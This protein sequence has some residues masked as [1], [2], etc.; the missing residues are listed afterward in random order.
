MGIFSNVFLLYVLL[1]QLYCS[2]PCSVLTYFSLA[3]SILV[4]IFHILGHFCRVLITLNLFWQTV[5]VNIALFK[6]L[7]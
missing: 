3:C 1:T 6:A 2:Q 7:P 4:F 5:T